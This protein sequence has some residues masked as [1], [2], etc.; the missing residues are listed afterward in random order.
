MCLAY[1]AVGAH[2]GVRQHLRS[3]PRETANINNT[4]IRKKLKEPLAVELIN[5]LHA[6][7]EFPPSYNNKDLKTNCV[8]QVA[9]GKFSKALSSWKTFIRNLI[10]SEGGCFKKVHQH[11]SLI[12]LEDYNR[13]METEAKAETKMRREQG[14]ELRSKNVGNHQLGSRGYLREKPIWMKEDEARA[15]SGEPDP[16]EK[17]KT[18]E[19]KDYIRSRYYQT[20]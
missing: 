7:Y 11:Y 10:S 3:N 14:K 19:A 1:R 4:N 12:S 6:R 20:N 13:F 15:F 5:W 16:F 2:E 8:N 18:K 9:L 17:F